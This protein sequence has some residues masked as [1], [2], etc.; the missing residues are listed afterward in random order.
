MR[1]LET[2]S[3]VEA[4][5]IAW[6]E[7]FA[8]VEDRFCWVQTPAI[9]R[10]LRGRYVRDIVRAA[11][12]NGTIL[13]LGCGSGWLSILLAKLGARKVVGIDFSKAQIEK[14]R[15]MARVERVADR[16]RFELADAAKYDR[17]EERFDVVVMHGFLHHLSTSE[18][19][20]ALEKAHK[21]LRSEGR[22]VVVEPIQYPTGPV[23]SRARN[24]VFWFHL[25]RQS[26]TR[27]RRWGLRRFSPAELR[28]RELI[29]E[30]PVGTEPFG[31]SPKEIPLNPDE[32]PRLVDGLFTIRERRRCMWASHFIAQELLLMQVSQP[33]LA[34][35]LTPLLIPI[36]AWLD[37]AILREER[38]P[39]RL[40]V[41]E[42]FIC[43]PIRAPEEV[44]RSG[45]REQL[46]GRAA[47]S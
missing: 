36:A 32:L 20:G 26:L 6:W 8:D 24:L 7:K 33:I 16:V 4:A 5:E 34:R 38:M 44:L 47:M 28:L 27:G 40:W 30:R 21:L 17:I 3:E 46:T 23:S 9:Q 41:F 35:L 39:G 1:P 12:P 14:A 37:R 15:T 45:P 19:R 18:I 29:D 13:E 31:P 11:P 42:M 22:L 25:I 2:S 10:S 43:Y